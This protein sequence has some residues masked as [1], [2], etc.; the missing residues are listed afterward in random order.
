MAKM[1]I[2]EI[3][4]S[5]QQQNK[6]I[7][8]ADLVAFLNANGFEAKGAQSSIEGN[9]IPFLLNAF[10]KGQIPFADNAAKVAKKNETEAVT[11]ETKQDTAPE[12]QEGPDTEKPKAEKKEAAAKDEHTAKPKS[13]QGAGIQAELMKSV[14]ALREDPKRDRDAM[15]AEPN[16]V[17]EERTTGT[18]PRAH[19]R[20]MEAESRIQD[21][22]AA[23]RT[24]RRN[25]TAEADTTRLPRRRS[26]AQDP[27]R[28][29]I[30][31]GHLYDRSRSSKSPRMISEA[32][33]YPRCSRYVTS[34]IA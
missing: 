8:S 9:A 34:R 30:V 25:I 33:R 5:M 12:K 18:L 7:K 17:A 20:L 21:E 22:A 1:R 14:R 10:E 16:Q 6:N 31:R 3:A 26:G 15:A 28:I 11:E 27:K 24:K 13:A 23:E 32:S 4:R 19:P 29:R 2:Y